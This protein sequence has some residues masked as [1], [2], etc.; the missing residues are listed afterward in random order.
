MDIAST[1][2]R[3]QLSIACATL[4]VE[5]ENLKAGEP[6]GWPSVLQEDRTVSRKD[7][8]ADAL[9]SLVAECPDSRFVIT[10]RPYAAAAG[11][12]ATEEFLDAG[13]QELTTP[14]IQAFIC[15]WHETG[16]E[17]VSTVE[18]IDEPDNLFA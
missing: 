14:D 9:G 7:S 15:G 16:K 4:L 6:Q 3:Y 10:S 8:K 13:P 18:K 12:L 17:G 11:W 2:K 5:R 1:S